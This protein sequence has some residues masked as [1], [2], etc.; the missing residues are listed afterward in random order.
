VVV[1]A[2]SEHVENAGVH[3]GDATLVLPPQRTYLETIR[4]IRKIT[5]NIARGLAISGPF[6]IQ[7][8]AKGN[9][10]KVIECNLRASRSF[11]FV[12]KVRGINF[13]DIAVRVMLGR[14]VA[15]ENDSTLNLDY[16]GVKAPQFSFMRLEGA[17]PLLGVEMTSTGE[18]GCLGD[19]FE[20]A[21]LKALLSV[22]YRLPVKSVLLS[23]GP[24]EQKAAF[25]KSARTLA[26][27]GVTLYATKGT[28]A[29]LRNNDL[30]P[31]VLNWPLENTS[32]NTLEYLQQRKIDLVINIPKTFQEEELSN[33]YLIRRRAVDLGIPLI[34][35]IQFARRF[36]EAICQKQMPG[37]AVKAYGEYVE[38][39]AGIRMHSV[40]GKEMGRS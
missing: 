39:A 30:D 1:S 34:T 18:V 40:E 38:E 35:N 36:V 16:V 19:D 13:I 7:F 21:F 28:A 8:I 2:I 20:E 24:V 4:R 22:G 26:K 33:D 14:P 3:S 10:V 17:D 31:I 27:M 15:K 23:T 6:N 29:F 32:P 25:L 37:L 9:E 5:E 11:P 12:S